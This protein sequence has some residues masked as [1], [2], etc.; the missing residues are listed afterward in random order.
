MMGHSNLDS[1]EVA[2]IDLNGSGSVVILSG[3]LVLVDPEC[4][5]SLSG[6]CWF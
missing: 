4:F 1:Y 6:S 5:R 2:R 3:P